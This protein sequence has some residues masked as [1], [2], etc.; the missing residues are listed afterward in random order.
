MAAD[1]QNQRNLT[2]NPAD[3]AGPAWSPDSRQI[4]FTSNRNADWEICVMNA[5][6][7]K[8]RNLTRSPKWDDSAAWSP[9]GQSIVFSSG[10]DADGD[11]AIYIMD[12]DGN[13]QRRLTN[14]PGAGGGLGDI[15][16][17]WFDPAFAYAVSLAGKSIETW[18]WLKQKCE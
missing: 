13:N 6:G 9:D 4:A 3:D 10:R 17:D 5:D 18:G 7:G 12:A 8:P 11:G 1:G 14:N 16:P 15:C 2:N